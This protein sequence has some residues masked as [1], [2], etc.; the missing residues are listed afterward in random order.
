MRHLSSLSVKIPKTKLFNACIIILLS[1]RQNKVS[2]LI[3]FFV[4]LQ[5]LKVDA[6]NLVLCM[7]R[8]FYEVNDDICTGL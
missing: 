8:F 5:I 7:D 2:L 1:T 6:Y 4:S 3:F